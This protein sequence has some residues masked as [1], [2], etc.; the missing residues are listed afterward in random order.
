ML[1]V[2]A[3]RGT[4]S[5]CADRREA[6]AAADAAAAAREDSGTS[7]VVVFQVPKSQLKSFCFLVTKKNFAKGNGANFETSK[8]KVATQLFYISF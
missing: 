5:A 4:T 6:A 3:R 8:K 2:K 7:I 1:W